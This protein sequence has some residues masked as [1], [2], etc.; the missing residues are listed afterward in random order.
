MRHAVYGI[1]IFLSAAGGLIVEITAGRLVA[2]YVGMSLYTWTAIIAVVLAGFSVGHWIGGVL[3]GAEVTAER[4]GRRVAWAFAGAAVTTLGSLVLLRLL[5][6]VLM[7]SGL[8]ILPIIILLTGGAFFLPS[9]TVGVISPILTKL[10]IDEA[11]GR[12]GRILGRFYALGALGSI[13]GTLAAGYVFISWIGSVGTLYLVAAIYALLGLVFAA[14]DRFRVLLVVGLIAG[15]AGMGRWGQGIGAF[16]SPCLIE[17]DYFCIRVEDF[18]PQTGRPSAI[19]ALDHLAHGIN[20]RDRPGL[21]YSPYI[22]CVDELARRRFGGP[23]DTAFHVGGGA[24]TLARAWAAAG[25]REPVRQLVAEI[26]PRVTEAAQQHMWLKRDAPGLEVDHADARLSLARLPADRRFQVIFGDAFHDISIPA[27]LISREFGVMVAR[28]LTE[29]GFYA[30]NVIDRG[31]QPLFL[32]AYVKTL[33]TVFNSVE[34]WVDSVE[35]RET[36]RVTFLV[37]SGQGGTGMDRLV[38]QHGIERE[39]R[40]WPDEDLNRRIHEADVP[41][42]TDDFA[43]VERLLAPLILSGG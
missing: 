24:Y 31:L 3:A 22:H 12:T 18:S 33:K 6:A 43:P 23:P 17:S 30:V 26:D 35:M 39:W 15:G 16:A 36:G 1:A 42:L 37:V 27:H 10:A 34:V 8:T 41:L 14:Q 5:A 38:S 32:F 11:P 2:P 40:R 9:L 21:L 28:R 20:D 4:G 25:R 13:A 19:M 29:D 7:P